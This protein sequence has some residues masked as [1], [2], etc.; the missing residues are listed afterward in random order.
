MSQHFTQ[1]KSTDMRDYRIYREI[2]FRHL[3]WAA[4]P[5]WFPKH[6]HTLANTRFH[7]GERNATQA[8]C[9]ATQALCIVGR[10][11]RGPVVPGVV[12]KR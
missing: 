10:R 11:R 12:S 8:L 4:Q 9:N 6:S 5:C 1:H 2:H 3:H 7:Q